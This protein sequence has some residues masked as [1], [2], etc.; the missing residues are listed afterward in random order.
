MFKIKYQ[1]SRL[2]N[3][4]TVVILAGLCVLLNNLTQI[5]FHRLELPKNKPE[6]SATGILI[7]LYNSSGSLLYKVEAESGV[8]YPETNKILLSKLKL[9]AFNESTT[10]LQEKLTSD[11]GWIDHTTSLGFLG[12]NVVLTIV[13][14]DP[15]KII[16]VYA[17]DVNLNAKTQFVISSAPVRATQGKSVLTGVGFNINYKKKLLTIESNLDIIYQK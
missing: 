16:Y 2:F 6:F 13:N 10:T 12:N 15:A 7:N 1:S 4:L 5:D 9:Q 3:I 8:Q 14:P 11:D 17:R